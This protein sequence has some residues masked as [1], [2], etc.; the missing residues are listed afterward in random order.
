ML[1]R[2]FS[3]FFTLAENFH[4]LILLQRQ[5]PC[6]C[7]CSWFA[8]LSLRDS[9]SYS[10]TVNTRSYSGLLRKVKEEVT[11]RKLEVLGS[12]FTQCTSYISKQIR[13]TKELGHIPNSSLAL[14][15]LMAGEL[16]AIWLSFH[17]QGS[18]SA[19]PHC[20][21]SYLSLCNF[22]CP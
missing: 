8:L 21:L 4:T 11:L 14:E 5:K 18:N 12:G 10:A 19:S 7:K 1:A 6:S 17:C 22:I 20:C 2:L 3:S 15:S 9:P 16:E 13:C